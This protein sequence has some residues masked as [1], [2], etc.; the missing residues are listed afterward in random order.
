MV[1]STTERQ[2]KKF[3]GL[4]RAEMSWVVVWVG[5]HTTQYLPLA[6]PCLVWYDEDTDGG[7]GV[8]A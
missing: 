2:Y 1:G 8:L 6:R 3:Q 7:R 4:A 5:L